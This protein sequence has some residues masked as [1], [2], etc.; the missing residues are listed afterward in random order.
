VIEKKKIREGMIAG[1]GE[2]NREIYTDSEKE[3][4]G[5]SEERQNTT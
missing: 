1:F 3:I 5:P 4:K 2:R